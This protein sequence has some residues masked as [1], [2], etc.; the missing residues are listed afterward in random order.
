MSSFCGSGQ[1]KAVLKDTSTGTGWL[2]SALAARSSKQVGRGDERV[3]SLFHQAFR[4]L[5][6]PLA[7]MV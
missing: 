3:K 1:A 2:G 4:L 6:T 5:A 7:G